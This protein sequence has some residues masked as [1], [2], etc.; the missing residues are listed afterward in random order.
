[1][2]QEAREWKSVAWQQFLV[3]R[4][5]LL[6]QYDEALI[7]AAKPPPHP[8]RSNRPHSRKCPQRGTQL[9]D[10]QN[11]SLAAIED[12]GLD[13]DALN[14]PA[15]MP[16]VE[17]TPLHGKPT[18]LKE[19]RNRGVQRGVPLER[20]SK[21]LEVKKTRL[22]LWLDPDPVIFGDQDVVNMLVICET[23]P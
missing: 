17:I 15:I 19:L 11:R 20:T 10:R 22:I 16:D 1:M 2:S 18:V 14:R 12:L 5:L 3:A 9:G 21:L 8:I 4:R 6:A 13:A 23:P 7:H